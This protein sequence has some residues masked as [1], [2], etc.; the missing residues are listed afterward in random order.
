MG[1]TRSV[2]ERTKRLRGAVCSQLAVERL[3]RNQR[4]LHAPKGTSKVDPVVTVSRSGNGSRGQG[5]SERRM[6]EGLDLSVGERTLVW[7]DVQEMKAQTRLFLL[8]EISS[9]A[10]ERFWSYAIRGKRPTRQLVS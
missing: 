8:G 1:Q 2:V 9:D 6:M 4:R 10:T 5:T 3:K 7:G